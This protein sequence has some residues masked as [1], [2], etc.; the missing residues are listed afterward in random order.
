MRKKLV[1]I[2]LFAMA[3]AISYG[4]GYSQTTKCPEVFVPPVEDCPV[5]FECSAPVLCPVCPTANGLPIEPELV[6]PDQPHQAGSL[7]EII[8][9]NRH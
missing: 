4:A 5:C 8:D 3:V 2:V 6:A 9:G 7:N 1:L